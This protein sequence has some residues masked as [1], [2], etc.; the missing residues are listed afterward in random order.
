MERQEAR[1]TFER[2]H[3]PLSDGKKHDEFQGLVAVPEAWTRDTPE[4]PSRKKRV[5]HLSRKI[6]TP[7]EETEERVVMVY[8]PDT[9]RLVP[10]IAID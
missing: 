2:R 8:D 3:L 4:R 7:M 10:L 1:V 6:E 5:K 9:N